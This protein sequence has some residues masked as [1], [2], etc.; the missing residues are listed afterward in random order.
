MVGSEALIRVSFPTTPFLSGTLK[1]TRIRTRLWLRSRSR[2]ERFAIGELLSYQRS[3]ISGQLSA[4]SHQQS[5]ISE[6]RQRPLFTSSLRRSTH[7]FE[8][9][10]SLSYHDRTLTKS[11][12]MT[13]VY[14]AST[15]EE[16][17][18]PLKSI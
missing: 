12:S 3:A 17:G 15:M 5:A 14:G 10:H 1:S 7:R 4:V 2:I 16:C 11:P 6:R 13:L 9:P 8:Y 18:S